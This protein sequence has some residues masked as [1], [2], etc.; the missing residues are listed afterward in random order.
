LI[1]LISGIILRF[2]IPRWFAGVM[3][4]IYAAFLLISI[5]VELHVIPIGY[6]LWEVGFS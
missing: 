3:M 2:T 4:P 5:L 1:F 6:S